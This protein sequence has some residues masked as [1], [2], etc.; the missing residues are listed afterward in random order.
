MG[1]RDVTLRDYYLSPGYI[2]ISEEPSLIS[3]VVGSCV[4]VS[5]WDCRKEYGAMA[6]YLYPVT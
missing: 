1:H 6:H 2:F 3:T 4:A 5:P